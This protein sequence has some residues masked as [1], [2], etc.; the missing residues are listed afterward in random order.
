MVSITQRTSMALYSDPNSQYSHRVRIVLEE[1]GLSTEIINMD[2]DNVDP[3][4]LEINPNAEPPVLIDRDVCLYDSTVLMEYLEERF[5]HPPLM[6]VYP[7]VKAI[8]R[9]FILRLQNEWCDDLDALIASNLSSSK[10]SKTKKDLK[11][12]IISAAPIFADK[13]YF[14]SDEFS[15]VDCCIAPILWRLPFVGIDISKDKKSKPIYEYMQ[16][17]FSRDSFKSSLSEIE[18]EMRDFS[19]KV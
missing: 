10:L 2:I 7:V 14:M 11:D 4:I 8:S 6:P 15:I 18:E 9:L 3:E 16:R 19:A 13:K 17:V 5:P 12:K 1:K